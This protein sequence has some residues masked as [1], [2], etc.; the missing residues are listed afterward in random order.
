MHSFVSYFLWLGVPLECPFCQAKVLDVAVAQS[1]ASTGLGFSEHRAQQDIEY[2]DSLAIDPAREKS[3]AAVLGFSELRA[4]QDTEYAESLAIDAAREK[5][6]A[7]R[8]Q[9]QEQDAAHARQKVADALSSLE[10]EPSVATPAAVVQIKL[11]DGRRLKRRFRPTA[12]LEQIYHLVNAEGG[13]G[14]KFQVVTVSPRRVFSAGGRDTFESAGL[15]GQVLYV[16]FVDEVN[17]A[18]GAIEPTDRFAGRHRLLL[19]SVATW[20]HPLHCKDLQSVAYPQP[21]LKA[22]AEGGL[23]AL[24]VPK[25]RRLCTENGLGG[26]GRKE[27]LVQRLGAAG[28]ESPT[29]A[30]PFVDRVTAESLKDEARILVGEMDASSTEITIA[31]GRAVLEQKLGLEAGSLSSRKDEVKQI[32]VEVFG[33]RDARGAASC[34][35]V[36]DKLASEELR[37]TRSRR[38]S[39]S[40]GSDADEPAGKKGKKASR[41]VADCSSERPGGW[42]R[43]FLGD[44]LQKELITE[45]DVARHEELSE[46]IRKCGAK[47]HRQAEKG[48]LVDERQAIRA[49]FAHAELT[50]STE[51]RSAA[52]GEL[53]GT[54]CSR[55]TAVGNM[56]ATMMKKV[57]E[58]HD[59]M[60]KGAV[61]DSVSI[62]Q[63]R[64]S[65]AALKNAEDASKESN[66]AQK[67]EKLDCQTRKLE[68]LVARK[69]AAQAELAG[70]RQTEKKRRGSEQKQ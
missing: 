24:S 39:H 20:C 19:P 6:K 42:Q 12:A 11:P 2:P 66:K 18:T 17:V 69:R 61:V 50:L 65:R 8:L 43:Q 40:H 7:A 53:A 34:P 32:F 57:N 9:A 45:Q 38:T 30:P 51:V 56:T 14:D 26:K 63:I 41:S 44:L 13:L 25:L 49:K 62:A 35:G 15:A 37:A 16:E 36:D 58:L 29:A 22:S 70:L 46:L 54:I 33:E 59:V 5:S 55:V 1:D 27:D 4:Q 3:V 67:I 64:A 48:P 60:V 52:A 47:R 21:Q 28:V 10:P 68:G 31:F 23:R